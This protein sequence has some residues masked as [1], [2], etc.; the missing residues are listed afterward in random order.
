MQVHE[1]E[2]IRCTEEEDKA[3]QEAKL[4]PLVQ[5][6][7]VKPI[8]GEAQSQWSIARR[9]SVVQRAI[10]RRHYV[11]NVRTRWQ[12]GDEWLKG[13]VGQLSKGRGESSS[14]R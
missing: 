6:V 14:T 10:N 13:K 8:P 7:H 5:A 4:G 3:Q 1:K 9:V 2:A 12:I 11:L